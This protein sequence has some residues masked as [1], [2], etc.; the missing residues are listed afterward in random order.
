[1]AG[2]TVPVAALCRRNTLAN[3]SFSLFLLMHSQEAEIRENNTVLVIRFKTL[4]SIISAWEA[5]N[6][7]LKNHILFVLW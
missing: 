3:A 2:F 4:F 6:Y 7:Y 5:S 1:M